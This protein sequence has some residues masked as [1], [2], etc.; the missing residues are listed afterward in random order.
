M[1]SMKISGGLTRGRVMTE[2]QRITWLLAMPACAEVNDAMQELTGVNYNTGEQNKDM[3]DARQVLNY[4]HDRNPF[5]PDPSLH[6]VSNGVHGHTSVNVDKAKTIG[7]T[8]L[9]SM[10]GQT[11]AE[12][13]FKKRDEAITLSTQSTLKSGGETVQVDPQLLF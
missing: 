13:A 2:Q 11:T 9:A 4:L 8:I 7:N 12:Y 6:S 1:R 3:T 5:C 10:D